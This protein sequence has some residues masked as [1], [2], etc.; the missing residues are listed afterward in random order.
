MREG[1]SGQAV[2]DK[3][4]DGTRDQVRKNMHGLYLLGSY[5]FTMTCLWKEMTESLV[6]QVYIYISKH[7]NIIN[8][9]SFDNAHHQHKGRQIPLDTPGILSSEYWSSAASEKGED[10]ESLARMRFFFFESGDVRG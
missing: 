6:G 8:P 7:F 5:I 3:A 10:I 2:G 9:Q 1:V 4:R